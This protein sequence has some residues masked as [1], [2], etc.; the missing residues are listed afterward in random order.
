MKSYFGVCVIH[1]FP[2]LFGVYTSVVQ[3]VNYTGGSSYVNTNKQ[4]LF[5]M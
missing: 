3:V 2:A 5:K 1:T 4:N